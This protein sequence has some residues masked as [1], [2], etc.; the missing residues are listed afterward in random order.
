MFGLELKEGL[1]YPIILDW[2]MIVI[3]VSTR[4]LTQAASL[5]SESLNWSQTCRES[6]F[7]ISG[8][9]NKSCSFRKLSAV[10]M[11][12]GSQTVVRI[13]VHDGKHLALSS[14]VL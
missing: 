1:F 10:T 9:E 3:T 8:R 4:A 11:C 7:V 12:Y 14:L 6:E 13:F 5:L 2:D